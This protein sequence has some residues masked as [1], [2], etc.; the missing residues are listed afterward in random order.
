[1][2]GPVIVCEIHGV[3]QHVGAIGL[4]DDG[5]VTLIVNGTADCPVCGRP[6]EVVN[7]TY[8]SV[9]GRVDVISNV[10]PAQVSLLRE[11]VQWAQEALR[12]G[13]DDAT[14]R[15]EIDKA[16]EAN[17]P[18]WKKAI[19]AVL[20]DKVVNAAQL[21]GFILMLLMFFGVEPGGAQ[22][23][24]APA[25]APPA[26]T[27]DEMRRLFEEYFGEERETDTPIPPAPAPEAP[28]SEEPPT[29]EA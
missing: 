19:D 2:P 15:E 9:S 25:P 14:V 18:G 24:P 3:Q 6:S 26:I 27:E 11:A 23:A 10:S 12:A 8:H 17:A 5:Q 13:V 22:E 21:L 20:S 16:L 29:T 7:G 28:T 1:M 4:P